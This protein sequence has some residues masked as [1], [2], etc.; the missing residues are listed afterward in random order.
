MPVAG[1]EYKPFRVGIVR[2]TAITNYQ[3]A[4]AAVHNSGVE[5]QNATVTG[6]SNPP[7]LECTT[8]FGEKPIDN[9]HLGDKALRINHQVRL[10]AVVVDRE[11]SR[12]TRSL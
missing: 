4:V 5:S 3:L 6:A 12:N 8:V 1:S 11:L 10:S 9:L 2:I 7:L